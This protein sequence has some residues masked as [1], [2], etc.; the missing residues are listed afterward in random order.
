MLPKAPTFRIYAS[1]GNEYVP[2]P[3]FPDPGD[4]NIKVTFSGDAY[5]REVRKICILVDIRRSFD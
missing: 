5:Y 4:C 3:G 2:P 1:P